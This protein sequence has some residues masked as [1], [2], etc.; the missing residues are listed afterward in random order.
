MSCLTTAGKGIHNPPTEDEV[1]AYLEAPI[2]ENPVLKFFIFACNG[3]ERD[4][5]AMTEQLK[6]VTKA[7]WISYGKNPDENNMFFC[8]SDYFHGDFFA[9]QYYYNALPV[10]WPKSGK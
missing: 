10:I 8:A 3:G 1:L 2:K 4:V 6:Y 9:P 7:P 5:K